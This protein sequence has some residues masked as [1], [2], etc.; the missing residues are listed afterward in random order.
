MKKYVLI[1]VL[2]NCLFLSLFGCGTDSNSGESAVHG[3][4]REQ[5]L[6]R[7]R[8]STLS[9]ADT[10]SANNGHHTG[11]GEENGEHQARDLSYVGEYVP[12]RLL[13]DDGTSVYRYLNRE[14]LIQYLDSGVDTRHLDYEVVLSMSPGAIER[15]FVLARPFF[16]NGLAMVKTASGED[17]PAELTDKDG[18]VITDGI[19]YDFEEF[20]QRYVIGLR[21]D[22]DQILYDLI[23]ADG[24]VVRTFQ[25]RNDLEAMREQA[26]IKTDVKTDIK[27]D[28]KTGRGA[29]LDKEIAEKYFYTKY[30]GNGYHYGALF[31]QEWEEF[32]KDQL[33]NEAEG[34]GVFEYAIRK[35]LIK[36][37]TQIGG[38][39]YISIT[40][41]K[42]DLFYIWDGIRNYFYD[43]KRREKMYDEADFGFLRD[44]R[45]YKDLLVA[46]ALN[47]AQVFITPNN[48][49]YNDVVVKI[50]GGYLYFNSIGDPM[51]YM[52][53]PVLSLENKE[54]EEK[55][56]V[57]LGEDINQ[58]FG[59]CPV[60][61]TDL[62]FMEILTGY[63]I[64]E[65]LLQLN[66]DFYSYTF[67]AAHPSYSREFRIYDLEE[68]TRIFPEDWFRDFEGAKAII[69]EEL[70]RQYE[71]KLGALNETDEEALQS[72]FLFDRLSDKISFKDGKMK[73]LYSPYEVA[74][75]AQGYVEMEIDLKK[76]EP[77][78]KE[79]YYHIFSN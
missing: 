63:E 53:S 18:V 9:N 10:S 62:H 13:K 33:K 41:V 15:D 4:N 36:D 72:F 26:D 60:G 22:S 78:M 30:L 66:Y 38:F 27:T 31:E 20:N 70:Q 39:D 54:A 3:Q 68:G 64:K 21:T 42:D 7:E 52:I 65:N 59:R 44:F 55:L 16:A 12:V 69:L 5:D 71:E 8:S 49:Y 47:R 19:Y 17:A 76:L 40:P 32:W 24:E 29:A 48:G 1:L 23:S 56:N 34:G 73:I 46:T 61:E 25:R 79:K 67:L 11:E 74:A 14:E 28:V 57:L 43:F 2:V 35:A 37:G 58:E 75:Y 77:Y 45:W 6:G 50:D 51:C